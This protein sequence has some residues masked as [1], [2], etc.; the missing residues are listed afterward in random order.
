[1]PAR[2]PDL[3]GAAEAALGYLGVEPHDDVLVL[4]NREQPTIAGALALAAE[5]RAK[6]TQGA[7]RLYRRAASVGAG[8]RHPARLYKM[9]ACV[10]GLKTCIFFM[11]STTSAD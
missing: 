8:R 2:P 1:M 11:L 5:R 6:T 9:A 3:N 7:Q 4:C 10:S